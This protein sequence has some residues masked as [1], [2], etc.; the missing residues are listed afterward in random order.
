MLWS[1]KGA[2]EGCWGAEVGHR[3]HSFCFCVQYVYP[4]TKIARSPPKIISSVVIYLFLAKKRKG[5][6]IPYYFASLLKAHK[7]AIQKCRMRRDCDV[8][9]IDFNCLIHRYLDE[10]NPVTSIVAAVRTIL[11]E[12]V[13]A[14]QIYIG[15]DGLAPYAKIVQQRYRRF[16]AA[17]TDAVFDRNQI[18][19]GTPYMKEL[20]VAIR[21][22]F[23]SAVVAGT[24]NPGEGEHKLFAWM[25]TLP[26]PS[27]KSIVVYG[28]DADLILL[29]LSQK[30]LSDPHN[31]FLLRESAEFKDLSPDRSGFCTLD[32]WKLATTL[33]V[34]FD[35]YIRL[36]ILCF[37]NDF[38]PNLALF[39]LREDGHS[40]A[41]HLY[42]RAG[43]PNL[44][45]EAGIRKFLT[46]A[47]SEET[48]VL[49]DR[50]A[51]RAIPYESSIVTSDASHLEERLAV[52]LFDGNRNWEHIASSFWRTYT[53]TLQY[54]LTN[55]V[56]DWNWV[57]PYAE[58][59]LVQT[60][61]RYPIQT[62]LVPGDKTPSFS[63]A[64]QLACILPSGSLAKAGSK[65]LY[66]DEFYVEEVDT[67]IPFMRRFRWESDPWMSVPWHP[68]EKLTKTT[69][70]VPLPLPD[71][72]GVGS[73]PSE[74]Q[75]S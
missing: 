70:W 54:F 61:L 51:A 15:S 48:R 16:R 21:A 22:Q 24:D 38:L 55:R 5:M 58:A 18:S 32:V 6:G 26:A 74:E 63:I 37:G 8:L 43:Y 45:T 4:N 9:A 42:K 14:K 75:T 60:L 1:G 69:R 57:Y 47:A 65:S 52:H 35:A 33:P 10:A 36:C 31:L 3:S 12:I 40:R 49:T 34:P 73:G 56:P 41:M 62:M 20:E 44:A 28:L 53:W 71:T 11:D 17:P 30:E 29:S 50:V 19:P 27:R 2:E 46:L 67:R 66:A 7:S 64:E 39:S 68:S 59:P 23:P 13:N 72:A 25:K